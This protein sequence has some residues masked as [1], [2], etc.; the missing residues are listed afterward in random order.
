MHVRLADQS[1]CI[2][3]AASKD[4]YLN[5]VNILSA[6]EITNADAIHP[7][8]GFLAE[9]AHFADVCGQCGIVFIGPP[10]HAI[11]KMGNKAV[12]RET[13][14]LAGGPV[15]PGSEGAPSDPATA[16]RLADDMGYRNPLGERTNESDPEGC[17]PGVAVNQATLIFRTKRNG[18]PTRI[19][20]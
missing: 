5:V 1:V 14:R 9:N 10:A 20:T 8:Y 18:S 7:G 15:V 19:R 13:M 17:T 11:A 16:V 4:S 3:P 12:A 6:A 2:G